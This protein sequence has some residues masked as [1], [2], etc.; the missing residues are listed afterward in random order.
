MELIKLSIVNKF[1]LI[2]IIWEVIR[3]QNLENQMFALVYVE[4]CLFEAKA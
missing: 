4:Q 2:S 3:K 1:Y